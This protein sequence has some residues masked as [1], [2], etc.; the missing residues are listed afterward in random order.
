MTVVRELNEHVVWE[1]LLDGLS[2]KTSCKEDLEFLDRAA[3]LLMMV[4]VGVSFGPAGVVVPRLWVRCVSS[5]VVDPRILAKTVPMRLTSLGLRELD[6]EW[7]NLATLS[8]AAAVREATPE[9]RR[10]D[11]GC[12]PGTET[13]EVRLLPK[14]DAPSSSSSR[15][16]WRSRSVGPTCA[17]KESLGACIL[18]GGRAGS[19]RLLLPTDSI[20]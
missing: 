13:T 14:K 4:P 1:L 6:C 7:K 2:S 11:S 19:V 10:G 8:V 15:P 18:Q 9:V 16:V 12:I 17:W 20:A 5:M 3:M